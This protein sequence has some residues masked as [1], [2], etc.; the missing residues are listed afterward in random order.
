MLGSDVDGRTGGRL[1]RPGTFSKMYSYDT[2]SSS[3][4]MWI[5]LPDLDMRVVLCNG[6]TASHEGFSL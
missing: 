5:G 4:V 2:G 3:V 6:L 1:C